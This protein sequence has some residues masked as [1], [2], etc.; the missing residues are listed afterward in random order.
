MFTPAEHR[1]TVAALWSL[2][3]AIMASVRRPSEPAVARARLEW[4]RAEAR[5]FGAGRE[6]H[7][8]TR[9]LA[10]AAPK[11][12]IQPEYLLEIVDAAESELQEVPCRNYA[13]LALYC[14]RAS[15]VLQEMIVGTLGVSEPENERAA[16]RF[17]QRLGSGIRL[18][19][20]ISGLRGDLAAG[21]RLL[22]RD[23]IVETGAE[24]QVGEDGRI[25]PA[26]RACLDRLAG[27]ARIAL[28]EASS[29]LPAAERPRQRTGLVLAALYRRQLARLHKAAF[30]PRALPGNL[31]N[32]WTAW[33][34]ARQAGRAH[35]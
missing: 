14:Y 4:W 16:R 1:E 17:A 13:E 32:L 33:R 23:W 10:D 12:V 27:E 28:D 25:D 22:P 6:Q 35:Q 3:A 26:T 21:R 20:I 2:R 18:V 5:G 24:E 8:A 15:G 19:E 29:T 34:A 30:N 31:D 9:L 7:P 11:G